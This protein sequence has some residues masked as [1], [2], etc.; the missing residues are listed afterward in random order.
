M[1]LFDGAAGR[2]RVR[3]HR[4]RRQAAA[5]ARWCWSS[6]PPRR[7]G[8]SPRW[9]TA[10]PP[11]P[12]VRIGGVILNRVGSDRHEAMLREAL[13]EVGVPVLGRAAPRRRGRP[14][15]PGTSGWCRSPSARAEA[16]R[17]SVRARSA[18]L[19]A[20]AR[21]T[22]TAL[23]GAGR[24]TR[25]RR[26][27]GAGRGTRSPRSARPAGAGRPVVAVAGG[28]AFTFALRRDTPSCSPPPAP[29]WSPFDPL[30]DEALPDGHRGRWSIGGGFPEVYAAE[31]SANE[32]LRAAVPRSP[33]RRR[34]SPPSAPG[35]STWRASLDGAPMCGVLDADAR[36]TARLTLGYRDAVAV[37]RLA[38]L[39]APATRVRGHEFHRTVDRARRTAPRPAWALDGDA[40]A[41]ASCTGGVHASYLHLHWAGHPDRPRWSR[42]AMAPDGR[43]AGQ[44]C[45]G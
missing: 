33:R 2:G 10:S 39:A 4:A 44:R 14:R 26:C 45:D 43:D 13:D 5:R 24:A 11:R 38:S 15:R 23:L 35:C 28:P 37:T 41:R 22:W 17:R 9:C 19:V 34:R 42:R 1:G 21:A 16:R 40:A 31:L 30:R 20:G 12:G 18:T 8:R 32:P 25:R 27:A 29:R 7:A 3:L 6:T 36:M